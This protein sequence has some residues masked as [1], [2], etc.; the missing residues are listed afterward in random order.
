MSVRAVAHTLRQ[1]LSSR[2]AL[3][4]SLADLKGLRDC[5]AT[6]QHLVEAVQWL[7]R[8]QDVMA[9]S[10]V[11]YGFDLRA[12][13][14]PAY[15]ETTGY[16]I[17][18]LLRCAYSVPANVIG[19][20]ALDLK[21]RAWR[22]AHWLTTVQLE[23]GA[24]PGGTVAVEPVSTVFNTG[25]VLDGWCEAYREQP[26]ETLKACLVRAAQWLVSVQDEDGCWRK[27]LSPLTV[28]TPATY[29]VRTAAALLKASYLLDQPAWTAA[30]L[31]NFDWVLTQQDERGWFDNNCLTET[32]RPLTHTT[33]YTL[34]G[35]LDA[36]HLSGKERYLN[37]VRR[38]SERLR[39]VVR[40]DGFLS[41]R[42][43]ANWRPLVSWC[44]LT[45]SCQLALVWFRLALMLGDPSYTTVASRL[46]SFVKAT[47][48]V[49]PVDQPAAPA[50]GIRGGIKGSHP[51]WGSYE[52]FRYPN[53]A[54]KFFV[55]A[56]LAAPR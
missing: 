36:A 31:K 9:S 50:D 15:P 18:T 25:Q 53:W 30:A 17:T 12:G 49:G 6:D 26:D 34:E 27:G 55:D 10:G 3:A 41:G 45:G 14:L 8:A 24:L 21:A 39:E 22:M 46:L 54:A 11:S 37:A 44:C 4:A 29:N 23:S 56:L 43:D 7:C 35:L 33:G 5:A 38:A 42:L 48:Q 28:Q 2:A 52:P 32:S 51:I 40:Q 13:W 20:D 19:L 47:Q 16:I 1:V